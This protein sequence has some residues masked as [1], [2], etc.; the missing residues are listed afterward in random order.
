MAENMAHA[1]GKAVLLATGDRED[2][3]PLTAPA[4]GAG[5]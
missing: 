5:R 3:E 1:P 4:D 2:T